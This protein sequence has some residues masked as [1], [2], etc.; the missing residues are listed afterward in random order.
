MS[1]LSWFSRG[2]VSEADVRAEIW[3]LGSRHLGEPMEGALTELNATDI[4]P[5][6]AA[7]LRACVRK[8]KRP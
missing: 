5:D 6:R 4:S 1:L 3:R 7:L 2:A 8:L